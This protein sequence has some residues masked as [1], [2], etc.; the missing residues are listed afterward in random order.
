MIKRGDVL[1]LQECCVRHRCMSQVHAIQ[2]L[3]RL[4]ERASVWRLT[5]SFCVDVQPT[6]TANDA[7]TVSYYTALLRTLAA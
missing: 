1:T 6:A 7:N 4:E 3:A 5:M 2:T